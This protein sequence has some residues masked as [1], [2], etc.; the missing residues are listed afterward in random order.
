MS[1]VKKA[2]VIIAVLLAAV[3]LFAAISYLF[4][5]PL[6]YR[7]YP[8]DRITGTVCV[9]TDGEKTDLNEGDVTAFYDYEEIGIGFHN[10]EDGAK[11]SIHGGEYGSYTLKIKVDGVGSP[12]EAVIYQ[13][14]WW[15]VSKFNMD[16][17]I[18]S[19]AKK[20][21]FT[22]NAEVLNEEG[23]WITEEHTTTAAFSDGK[24]IHRN[25]SER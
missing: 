14:N 6:F 12:L 24:Y 17:S 23:K 1:A 10:A 8:F 20:I 4:F 22:S 2:T 5:K 13:S 11:I 19:A 16:I 15:N 21:T 3:L 18:E 25:Y 9:T 7:F